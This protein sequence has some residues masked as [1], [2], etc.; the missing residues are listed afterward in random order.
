[1]SVDCRNGSRP[2][3]AK[4]DPDRPFEHSSASASVVFFS[5]MEDVRVFAG[6]EPDEPLSRSPPAML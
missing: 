1:M 2:G 3:E 4:A 6:E 5:S